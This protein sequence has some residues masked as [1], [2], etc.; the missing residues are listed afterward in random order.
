M[1]G[2]GYVGHVVQKGAN[3]MSSNDAQVMYT[4]VTCGKF[5]RP[6]S[7]RLPRVGEDVVQWLQSVAIPAVSA[8]HR[9]ASPTCIAPAMNKIALPL[10]KQG[11]VRRAE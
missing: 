10:D 9:V 4:C 8:D 7:V 11:N 5:S 3:T 1:V 2:S 6:V